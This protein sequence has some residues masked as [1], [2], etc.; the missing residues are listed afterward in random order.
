MPHN[1]DFSKIN[2]V[3]TV[4]INLDGWINPLHIEYGMALYGDTPSYY[5]RVRGTEHTFVIPVLRLNFLSSGDHV[6]HF[7]EVLE[8]FREEY[9]QWKETEFATEWMQEYR[10][11]YSKYIII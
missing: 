5:W 7:K 6:E 4:E 11:Q 9:I 2:D 1:Y 3:N 8:V 10:D